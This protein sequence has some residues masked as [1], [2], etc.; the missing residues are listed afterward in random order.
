MKNLLLVDDERPFLLSLRDGLAALGDRY[1][2]FMAND[3]REALQVLKTQTIDLLVTDLKLPVM[4][5]FQLLAHVSRDYPYLPV[6]VM[7]AFGTPEIEA[8]LARMQ[9]LQYLDK[10]LDF[11]HLAQTIETALATEARS[12]IRGI[13]LATFMQLVQ[14]EQKSC[15]LKI[16]CGDKT[17]YLFFRRGELL[18]AMTATTQGEPAAL[19]IIAWDNTTIEM[20]AVCRREEKAIAAS[21][22]FLLME[23]YRLKDEAL[24]QPAINTE[25]PAP[26]AAPPTAASR[27]IETLQ[28]STL[29]AE[30]AIFDQV[31]F[32]EH[33]STGAGPLMQ[34][35]PT[36]CINACQNIGTVVGGAFRYLL[37]STGGG[38]RH[39]VLQQRQ[40]RLVVTLNKGAKPEQVLESLT[41]ALLSA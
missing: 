3:G 35:D 27:L 10:P 28:A 33:H 32:L 36:A 4:D 16:H 23:A 38:L 24:Q 39:L 9:N 18:D 13:T 11:D 40:L 12:Y 20:D 2:I 1:R 25:P 21:M 14:M 34:L 15:T 30:Y 29:I 41:P 37:F 8:K 17:G 26:V 6:I 7:T 19:E 5:G 31:N 22:S